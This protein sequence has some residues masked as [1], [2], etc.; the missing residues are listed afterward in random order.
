MPVSDRRRQVLALMAVIIE[1]TIESES[2]PFG[3]AVSA[4]PDVRV[5]LERQVPLNE[6]RVPF[7][8]AT[9]EDLGRFER[10]LTDSEIV[11]D[12]EALTRI[13]NSVLYEVE[14]H[15]GRETFMNGVADAGGTIMEANGD[16]TWSFTV[17]FSDHGDL[18]RFHQ[19]YQEEGFPVHIERVSTL[20]DDPSEDYRFGLT[21]TQREALTAAVENG[22]FSVPRETKLEEIADD[23]DIT[24]QA[25]S[26]L[27]RRG[28]EKVLR[29]ALLGLAATEP[30]AA[31]AE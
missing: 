31:S 26:E 12:V 21:P 28:T 29:K 22:Y 1:F 7:V 9:G 8:W 13:E 14:W 4:D 20:S 16:S 23:L 2:F 25:A 30:E 3:R 5:S 17:R 24:R 11:K 10:G 19:F 6:G 27:V 18:T 15:V